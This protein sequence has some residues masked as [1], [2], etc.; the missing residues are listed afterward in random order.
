MTNE[1]LLD[2]QGKL[3]SCT[4][5]GRPSIG[6]GCSSDPTYVVSCRAEG[7]C[8][9]SPHFHNV[10]DTCRVWNGTMAAARVAGITFRHPAPRP[11]R[12]SVLY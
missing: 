4:C 1:E 10:E 2:L 12:G 6:I 8:W 7:E 9:R 11:S 5:G 3:E